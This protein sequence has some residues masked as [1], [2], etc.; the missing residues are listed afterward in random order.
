M[1]QIKL[2]KEK[3][4][5]LQKLQGNKFGGIG[6]NGQLANKF[7]KTIDAEKEFDE[8]SKMTTISLIEKM[9][10]VCLSD[11][12]AIQRGDAAM[13]RFKMIDELSDLLNKKHVQ[14]VFLANHGCRFLEMW[15]ERNPDGSYPPVQVVECVLSVLDRLPIDQDHLESCNIA[16]MVTQYAASESSTNEDGEIPKNVISA[17]TKLLQKWQTVVY[18]LSYEYDKDGQHEIK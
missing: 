14:Q 5:L 7:T 17:A 13:N 3:Q 10:A 15:L 4:Q 18:Q 12:D 11:Y 2:E 9:H 16:H 6:K 1:R 8:E